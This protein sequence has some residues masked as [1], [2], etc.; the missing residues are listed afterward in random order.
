MSQIH[1][2]FTSE[3]VKSLLDRY[4][5]KE[6]ERRYIQEIL[7]IRKRQFFM[8]LRQYKESPQHFTIR[9]H[10][11]KAPRSLIPFPIA[12]KY[13]VPMVLHIE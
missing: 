5:K 11:T 10:R 4:S 13:V 6:I 12:V 7:G 2:R 8:I 1:K 9:Y 3:Q